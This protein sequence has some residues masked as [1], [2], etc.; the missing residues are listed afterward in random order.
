MTMNLV[1]FFLGPEDILCPVFQNGREIEE[2]MKEFLE[3][4]HQISWKGPI[5][6]DCF[7]SGLD[8]NIG[9]WMPAGDPSMSLANYLDIVLWLCGSP[10]TIGE[11]EDD[12]ATHL[13]SSQLTPTIIMPSII[14]TK[15]IPTTD[16]E[17][18]LELMA[19]TD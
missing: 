16:P 4:C 14:Y 6:K 11:V 12:I 15:P 1:R 7:W 19:T 2:Y 17:P 13:L 3:Y 18:E 8:K 10:F 9:L 5:L